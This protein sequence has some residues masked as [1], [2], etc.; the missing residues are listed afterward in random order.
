[1]YAKIKNFLFGSLPNDATKYLDGTGA[2]SIPAGGGGGLVLLEQHTASASATLD[3]TTGIT[4]AYDDYLIKIVDLLPA[5]DNVE[6]KL[7]FSTNGGSSYDTSAIYSEAVSYVTDSGGSGIGTTTTNT[8]ISIMSSAGNA[9][10]RGVA[11][12]YNLTDPLSASKYKK[13]IGGVIG[14]NNTGVLVVVMAG[15]SYQ[16]I[17]A[18]NAF[19]IKYS[20][21]NIASGTVRLYGYEK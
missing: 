10:T 14:F 20:S 11:A 21:G 2:F 9:S 16:N 6:L 8:S 18:V 19:Q 12:N 17:A 7:L 13:V 1:M 5:T 3:F 15:W 4:S